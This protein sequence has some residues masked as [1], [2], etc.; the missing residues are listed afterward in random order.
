MTEP[1]FVDEYEEILY[2]MEGTYASRRML[3]EPFV[4]KLNEIVRIGN[5]R[6]RGDQEYG[7]LGGLVNCFEHA[8]FNL[9]NEQIISLGLN[10]FKY[11]F[12]NP[13]GGFDDSS[14]LTAKEEMV[15]FLQQTGLE[16]EDEKT[17]KILKENQYRVALY[18]SE[19]FTKSNR[20]KDFHLLVQEADGS[21]SGKRGSDSDIVDH[22]DKLE[23]SLPHDISNRYILDSVMVITNPYAP[24]ERQK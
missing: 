11:S 12:V 6:N 5:V 9:T 21:W 15:E 22:F 2:Y 17:P 7:V 23:E 1:V 3:R 20:G 4:K 13:F 8:C 24:A 16:V 18:F 10:E 14:A 19:G